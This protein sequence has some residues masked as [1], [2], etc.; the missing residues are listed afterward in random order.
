MRIRAALAMVVL[1]FVGVAPVVA[2]P[3]S[4]SP[5]NPAA[6]EARFVT[7]LNQ[8][9]AKGGLPPLTVDGQLTSLAR[10]WAQHMADGGC[11]DGKRICHADPI[12]AGLDAPWRKLGENVGVGPNVDAVMD[13]FIKSG[14]HYANIMDPAFTRVGVGVVWVG[15]AMY[16]THRFMRLAGDPSVDAPRQDPAPA[17]QPDAPAPDPAPSEPAKAPVTT[18]RPARETAAATNASEDT[19]PVAAPASP[20]TTTTTT[21]APA[22]PPP[23]SPSRVAAVLASLRAVSL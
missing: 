20:P 6:D 15:D 22:P 4:A 21:P 3:A 10:D 1:L 19:Q 8:T 14:G 16:T 9:R 13:A 23:A 7:L 2:T 18:K 12:S 11:G 17:P 5:D